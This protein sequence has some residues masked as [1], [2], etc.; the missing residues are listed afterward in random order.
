MKGCEVPFIT[1]D[2]EAYGTNYTKQEATHCP[3]RRRYRFSQYTLH[4]VTVL[5]DELCFSC[6]SICPSA[7][8]QHK[9]TLTHLV[10]AVD[11]VN[12]RSVS[13]KWHLLEDPGYRCSRGSLLF[14]FN[15]YLFIWQ[16]WGSWIF[17]AA[18][19]IFSCGM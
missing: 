5:P 15:I 4:S 6:K 17:M 12:K 11:P 9:I 3:P 10:L 16:G 7:S 19:G 13:Q 18:R 1:K 14:F 2:V 8:H